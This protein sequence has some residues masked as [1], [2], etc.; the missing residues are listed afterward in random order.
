LTCLVE[1]IYTKGPPLIT[2]TVFKPPFK[3]YFMLIPYI[4]ALFGIVLVLIA[5][6]LK[7]GVEDVA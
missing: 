4:L 3:T 2:G 1:D 7:Q 6:G 5:R